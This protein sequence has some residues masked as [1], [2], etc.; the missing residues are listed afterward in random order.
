MSTREKEDKER[1]GQGG[2]QGG[3]TPFPLDLTIARMELG[4]CP[5]FIAWWGRR[6]GRGG[7]RRERIILEV[8]YT[9]LWPQAW[10]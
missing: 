8:L 10:I 2:P 9:N 7:S 3:T 1:E 4:E 5:F 6:R